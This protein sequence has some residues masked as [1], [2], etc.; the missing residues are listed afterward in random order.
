MHGWRMCVVAGLIGCGVAGCAGPGERGGGEAVVGE[1]AEGEGDAFS[2]L[3]D[4]SL[5]TAVRADAAREVGAMVRAGAVERG[6]G[7]EALKKVVWDGRASVALRRVAFEE[8]LLDE[9]MEGDTRRMVELMLPTEPRRSSRLEMVGVF[10]AAAVE[11]GWVELAPAFVRSWALG[12]VRVDDAE[13]PERAALVGLFD[14]EDVAGTVWRVFSGELR[15]TTGEALDEEAVRAAWGLLG[16]IVEDDGEL[17]GY[18]R[19]ASGVGAGGGL[20]ALI[21]RGAEELGVLPRTSEELAWLERLMGSEYSGFRGEAS[22]VVAGLGEGAREGLELRHLAG[23][24]YAGRH[25]PAALRMT[26][27]ELLNDLELRVDGRERSFRR[28]DRA[29]DV[30][31]ESVV[32]NRDEMSWGDA[33]LVR[34]AAGLVAGADADARRALAELG[35]RDMLDTTTEHGGVIGADESGGLVMYHYPPR[36]TQRISDRRMVASEALVEAGTA[37][38]FHFHLH[39]QRYDNGAYSGPSSGDFAYARLYGRSCLVLTF[40]DADVMNVDYYQPNGVVI[41]LGMIRRPG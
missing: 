12:S 26:R 17:R 4:G 41:D 20:S 38:L 22:A 13:R 11:R 18:V 2:V 15:G 5:A 16:R 30:S 36:A 24:V 40:M 31:N 34:V 27:E 19:S 9:G 7:R 28:R 25:D 37:E 8:L 23:L 3:A 1:V 10:G 29:S 14:D 33:L 35:D 32:W 21:V 6:V 39:A